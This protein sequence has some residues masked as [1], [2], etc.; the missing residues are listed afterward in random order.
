M[1][2]RNYVSQEENDRFPLRY[3]GAIY[4]LILCEIRVFDKQACLISNTTH[5]EMFTNTKKNYENM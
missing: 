1:C 4:D 5:H 3:F 2:L